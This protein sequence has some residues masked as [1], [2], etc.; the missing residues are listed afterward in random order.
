VDGGDR[1]PY[2]PRRRQK[3]TQTPC[4]SLRRALLSWW[5]QGPNARGTA[6]SGRLA[7]SLRG[8]R[9]EGSSDSVPGPVA[10]RRAAPRPGSHR[11]S[12]AG[13]GRPAPCWLRPGHASSPAVPVA[14]APAGLRVRVAT[15]AGRAGTP[16]AHSQRDIRPLVPRAPGAPEEKSSAWRGQRSSGTPA[17]TR[18]AGGVRPTPRPCGSAP[19]GAR[20]TLTATAISRCTI[21][22]MMPVLSYPSVT[23]GLP[24]RPSGPVRRARTCSSRWHPGHTGTTSSCSAAP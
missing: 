14:L 4:R 24:R 2:P 7:K 22:P 1:G 21:V 18:A 17:A 15:R 6:P 12:L 11:L 19:G 16:T 20:R 5:S 3:E 23:P 10:C 9:P 8:C 13:G